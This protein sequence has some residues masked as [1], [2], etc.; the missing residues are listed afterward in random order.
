MLSLDF[1]TLKEAAMAV[2]LG[3]MMGLERERSGFERIQESR[4]EPQR[5]ESDHAESLH[6]SLGA[7]TFALLTLLGWISVKVGG[8]GLAMPIAVQA[9]VAL[10][11]GLF[12]Y[13]TS[14]PDR[15]LTTEVAALAAPLLGML[16]TRDALLAVALAVIVTL[17]LLSKPWIRAWIPRLHREDLTSAMQ[18]LIVFAIMLP[19]LPSRTLDPW[20]V[21]S[22]RR[23]GGW[24]PSSP[25][26]ISS[27]T[28]STACWGPGGGPC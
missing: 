20:G 12:Y 6:G 10:L 13:R 1:S 5:R 3:L 7:R 25:R 11:V 21:L 28:R 27:A 24:W 2:A 9:F 16:L 8:D 23:S 4:D 18:L 22:P 15:G 14:S 26:W 17:L 19:L